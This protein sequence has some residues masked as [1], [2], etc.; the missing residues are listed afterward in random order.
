MSDM[1]VEVIPARSDNYVFLLH[2]PAAGVTAV[3][4]PADAAPVE[5]RLSARGLKPDWIL[6]T[7]RHADHVAGNEA[8]I[9]AHGCRVA[10][11]RAEADAIPG[12]EVALGQGD[13]FTLGD[14]EARIY[15]TP[16]HTHG[17]I[18]YWFPAAKA[19][20]CGDLLF[21]LGCGRV[22]EGTMAQMW[23]SLAKLKEMP[24][25]TVVYCGHEYTAANARFALT[26]EPGNEELQLRAKEIE[27]LRAAGKPTVPT[28]LGAER[29]TNPF[30]RVDEPAIRALL[31]MET[32]GAAEVFGE[33][34]RRKDAF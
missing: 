27:R 24:D 2:L 15:D 34:R 1:Q 23:T 11:P 20:F 33:I 21:V 30:L 12:I 4:D 14:Q 28:T 31:G 17:H 26:I 16:G 22:F 19:L 3:V 29:R 9:A 25:D 18:S 10:G 8:L 32:A 6:N 7:H 13:R 5:A